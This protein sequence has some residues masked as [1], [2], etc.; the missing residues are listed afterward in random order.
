MPRF[1]PQTHSSFLSGRL[2]IHVNQEN[3]ATEQPGAGV[4][5]NMTMLPTKLAAAGYACHHVGKW[6]AG[7]ATFGHI[8]AGRGFESSLGFFNFGED[9]YTQIRGGAALASARDGAAGGDAADCLGVDL[10]RDAAPARGENGSYGGY[11]F[12][13]QA[14]DVIARHDNASGA[15]PLFLYAAFQNL[16]TPLQVPD[17]YTARYADG[18]LRTTVNGMTS[19]LDE[20]VGN[21]TAALRARAL[22]ENALIVYS[23]DNGGYLGNGGDDF[24]LRGGKF[25]DFQGGVRVAAWASG[26]RVPAALRGGAVAGYVSICDWYATFL[27]LAGLDAAAIAADT[28]GVPAV[29]SLD[30]WPL[31]SGANATSPRVE[32]PLSVLPAADH[33]ALLAARASDRAGAMVAAATAAGRRFADSAGVGYFVGG[34]GLIV[35]D[36]KILT[37]YQHYGPFD[38]PTNRTCGTLVDGRAWNATHPGVPCDCGANGCLFNVRDDPN[39]ENDLAAA[40][41]EKLAELHARLS[42]LREGV[43]APDRG[44]EDPAACD[45]IATNRGFWGP[46]LA[47]P[48]AHQ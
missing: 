16:H 41:P 21:L 29:D 36:F 32:V 38:D 45:Q 20:A 13:A 8:P 1:L 46:W 34:E 42:A 33:A 4:P 15:A 30:V 5:L 3:S 19:F 11:A 43:Y 25:S 10:W 28:P 40:M 18:P 24:P 31:L 2:A 44:D 26:G 27:G 9:H 47:A 35:G 6:H 14:V 22:Y 12:T 17:A 23:P 7:Q 48:G 39:E 37:G